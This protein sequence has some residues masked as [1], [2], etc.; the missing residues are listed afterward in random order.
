MGETLLQRAEVIRISDETI[1]VRPHL[2]TGCAQCRLSSACGQ[3]V[4]NRWSSQRRSEIALMRNES[5]IAR[6]VALGDLVELSVPGAHFVRASALQFV[7]PLLGM[8]LPAMLAE[9]LGMADTAIALL[10]FGGLGFALWAVSRWGRPALKSPS[11]RRI[12]HHL[13]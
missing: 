12:L 3:G 4:L 9:S 6:H 2:E 10:A 8:V 5:L 11:I 7:L 13:D 1:W